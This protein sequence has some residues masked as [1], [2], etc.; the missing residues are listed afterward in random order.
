VHEIRLALAGTM[1]LARGDAGGLSW[2][3]ASIEG[4]WRSFRAALISYPMFLVLLTFRVTA[5]QLEHSSIARIAVVETIGYT[6][7]WAAFPLLVLPL[8]RVLDRENRFLLFMVAYNWSQV[9]QTALFV[10]VAIL[11]AVLPTGLG[12][13]IELA[14]AVAVLVYE[15]F[16][17][18]VAL[19]IPGVAATLVV[20]ID[21]LLG[22]VLNRVTEGLY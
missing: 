11:A 10:I 13:G 20:L 22:T 14:A 18:R 5:A 19:V 15:W 16:I 21:M 9:L 3:D 8:T 4:F 12:Q 6:I 1:Q 2:F 7:A 17:A